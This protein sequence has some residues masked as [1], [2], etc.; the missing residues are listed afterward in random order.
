MLHGS[1][2]HAPNFEPAKPN[3]SARGAGVAHKARLAA[4]LAARLG[5]FWRARPNASLA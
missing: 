3:T 2:F 5:D 1:D 4:R